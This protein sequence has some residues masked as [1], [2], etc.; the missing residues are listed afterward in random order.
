MEP[1]A[2]LIVRVAAT[3]AGVAAAS[4]P[5]A[6]RADADAR[7]R[8]RSLELGVA[9]GAFVADEEHGFHHP[10]VTDPA[11]LQRVSPQALVRVAFF[12]LAFAGLE[13]EG[14]ATFTETDEGGTATLLALHGSV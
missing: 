4:V 9:A 5:S 11:A 10:A 3:A 13:A 6:T 2:G 14:G 1:R 7:A 12:P 8:G